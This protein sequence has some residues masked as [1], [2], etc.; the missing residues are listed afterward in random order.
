MSMQFIICVRL[1]K[2]LNQKLES[3][4]NVRPLKP[5]YKDQTNA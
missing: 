2:C 4:T 1:R 5:E 3:Q